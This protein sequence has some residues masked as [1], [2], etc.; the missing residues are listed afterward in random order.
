[1]SNSSTESELTWHE[2]GTAIAVSDNITSQFVQETFGFAVFVKEAQLW[3]PALG[4]IR[5][6]QVRDLENIS[7]TPTMR[8]MAEDTTE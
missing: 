7:N 5:R 2:P 1:M 6:R 8:K 4:S 3:H